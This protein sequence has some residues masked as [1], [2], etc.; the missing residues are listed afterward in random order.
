MIMCKNDRRFYF[1]ALQNKYY[2]IY[3]DGNFVVL[4]GKNDFTDGEGEK[5]I[6]SAKEG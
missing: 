6:P 3:Y 5:F 2:P 4:E 1:D